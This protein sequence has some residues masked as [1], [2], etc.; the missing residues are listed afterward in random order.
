MVEK[1][2]T[3][4]PG[5]LSNPPPTPPD[6]KELKVQ[7]RLDNVKNTW[8]HLEWRAPSTF[9]MGKSRIIVS[10]TRKSHPHIYRI[11]ICESNLARQ[12]E[13]SLKPL[14]LFHMSTWERSHGES[15]RKLGRVTGQLLKA[16][17]GFLFV[18]STRSEVSGCALAKTKNVF[19]GFFFLGV[20]ASLPHFQCVSLLH[21]NCKEP[22]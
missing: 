16:P 22:D 8:I 14:D 20:I 13:H 9:W 21:R 3:H 11:T 19:W 1:W 5:L 10:C 6:Y 7:G 12:V 15:V 4:P 17:P 2:G 18:L